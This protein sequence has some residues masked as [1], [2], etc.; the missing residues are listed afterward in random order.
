MRKFFLLALLVLS[1]NSLIAKRAL[2]LPNGKSCDWDWS[3]AS[4]ILKGVKGPVDTLRPDLAPPFYS[5]PTSYRTE[6]EATLFTPAK[7]CSILA[8]IHGVVSDTPSVSKPCT[9]YIW[10]DT[11]DGPGL[12]LY[13]VL[14]T[15]YVDSAEVVYPNIKIIP[16]LV[17]VSSPFWV[18]NNEWDSAD[19]TTAFDTSGPSLPSMYNDGFLWDWDDVDYFHAAV[20]A[21]DS[22]P[23]PEK[24]W[25]ILVF[26]NGDNDIEWNA[27]WDINEMEA[28]IDTSVCNVIVQIDRIPG[29][30]VSNGDWT[31]TRR[32]F[33]TNDTTSDFD[34]RSTLISDLGEI[35]MGDPNELVNFVNWGIS[36]YPEEYYMVVIWGDG[37][38]W[39][40]GKKTKGF[41][42]DWT[43]GNSSIDVANGELSDAMDSI[44][45][46]LGRKI[47][48]VTLDASFMGMQEVAYELKDAVQFMLFSEYTSPSSG[49]RYDVILDS[50]RTNSW[51][52]AEDFTKI[53]IKKNV[54]FYYGD[55]SMTL[56][57]VVSDARFIH[58]SS[59]ID[60][61]AIALMKAGGRTNSD[62]ITERGNVLEFLQDYYIDI[63]DFALKIKNDV[64][65][66][67]YL[68]PFADSVINA[69]AEAVVAEGHVSMGF[70]LS[71][72]RGISIYYPSDIA[73]IDSSYMELGFAE[74]L[75]NWWNFITGQVIGIEDNK[76]L[77]TFALS[78]PMP[79]PVS[80]ITIMKY[81]IPYKTKAELNMYDLTGT[82]VKTLYTGT[83]EPGEYTVKLNSNGLAKGVYFVRLKT[84]A[85]T[86]TQKFTVLR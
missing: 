76:L 73:D 83:R 65:L 58:L 82:L 23:A 2:L 66:P 68:V 53:I 15:M 38:G 85:F 86:K 59:C 43:D 4:E 45:T 35:N 60:N 10:N 18:G 16:F 8:I 26:M 56:S 14:D 39:Y 9:L 80:G 69:V 41:K 74:E 40:K 17:H 55:E 24:K 49:L 47:D 70:S 3:K 33:L 27:L 28:G 44:K 81:I 67:W 25:T 34:I 84:D 1:S 19:P 78:S 36:N 63:S 29:H 77:S 21:Y 11:Y 57:S 51:A 52:T 61:F 75:P 79:N 31:T 12:P 50:L 64:N 71:K 7:P 54:D 72:A 37:D 46:I 42:G 13:Q 22:I 48:I 62:I 32:Y 6:Y 20:V 30:D 5:W